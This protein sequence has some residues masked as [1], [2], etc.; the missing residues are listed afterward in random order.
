MAKTPKIG[1]WKVVFLTEVD[2][3]KTNWYLKP[4]SSFLS[5]QIVSQNIVNSLIVAHNKIKLKFQENYRYLSK[6][7]ISN[8]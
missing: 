2:F 4:S 7:Y 5:I 1:V 8:F 6:N 3:T